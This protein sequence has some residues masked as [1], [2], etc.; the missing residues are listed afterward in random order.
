[1]LRPAGKLLLTSGK[2]GVHFAKI[3]SAVMAISGFG[4]TTLKKS[5]SLH[6]VAGVVVTTGL[7]ALGGLLAPRSAQAL[8]NQ[9]V[10]PIVLINQTSI[11]NNLNTN[12]QDP[13]C[14][15]DPNPELSLREGIPATC[16]PN[17]GQG[18]I[19]IQT[20][21][22]PGGFTFGYTFDVFSP[23]VVNAL[24][25]YH[26]TNSTLRPDYK[27]ESDHTVSLFQFTGSDYN[28]QAGDVNFWS[29]VTSATQSGS[30][31][32]PV[33]CSGVVKDLFCWLPIT[34]VKINP[35]IYM[36]SATGGWF[37]DY[38][39]DGGNV[40]EA[41]PQTAWIESVFSVY[42]PGVDSPNLVPA[43]C[44]TYPAGSDCSN[45]Y[46]LWAANVSTDVPA[47]LPALGAAAGFAWTR[48][49]RRRIAVSQA[50]T[51]G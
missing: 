9:Q 41:N 34:L 6:S 38:F 25:V 37:E 48:R 2:C 26:A 46:P 13:N 45:V 40:I 44:Y 11:P 28:S 43:D 27:Y 51:K 4:S 12:A 30:T 17:F 32:T 18:T 29:L 14:L 49:L 1:M 3:F 24:G 5:S 23:Q 47:P 15:T 50:Q 42:T 16:P 7:L 22:D 8:T 21:T 33:A 31:S 39:A 35:G 20:N 19:D 36:V 10:N